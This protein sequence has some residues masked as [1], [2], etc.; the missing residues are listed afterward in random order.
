M[1]LIKDYNPLTIPSKLEFVP[2]ME[3][4]KHKTDFDRNKMYYVSINGEIV[5]CIRQ[6]ADQCAWPPDKYAIPETRIPWV[7]ESFACLVKEYPFRIKEFSYNGFMGK[8]GD[9]L[10]SY[11]AKFLRWSGDPG[12]AVMMCSDGE[13]RFIPTFAMIE[14][15]MCLPIDDTPQEAKLLFG[16]RSSS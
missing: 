12:V 14:S 6:Y 10:M 7:E 5:T 13:E 9:K 16:Y 4:G 3:N 2:V 1:Y 11:Q 8:Q 15:T